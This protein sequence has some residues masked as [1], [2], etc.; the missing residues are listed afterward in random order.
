MIRLIVKGHEG[1]LPLRLMKSNRRPAAWRH[2][3]E[4]WVQHRHTDNAAALTFYALISLAP[5]LLFGVTLAGVILGETTAHGE[6][7]RQ[8][9][10]VIGS[11][12]AAGI[13]SMLRSARIA[14]RSEPWAFA[15][16]M[17][18][19]L[20]A[21]SHVLSKLRLSLNQV[22]EAVPA[23][24]GRK[25][26][27]R[28]LARSLCASL[29]LVFGVLLVAATALEGAAGYVAARVD[30]PL[31]EGLHFMQ[32]WRWISSYLLLIVALALILKILPRRR[33][34]WRHA[35]VGAAVA[36]LVVGSLKTVLDFY[37]R[38]TMWASVIGSGI[39]LL[40]FL[41]W[42]F[43]SIQAFLAGAELAAWLGKRSLLRNK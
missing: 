31:L 41:L 39:T 33:P 12:A 43:F 38:R 8:L 17:I 32:G 23:D 25:W 14:P 37:L 30:L 1:R 7:L 9:S 4:R 2:F 11:D 19:L 21:G 24:P 18:T 15:L 34:K 20:Y 6:L 3:S 16:A 29:I 36:A 22:N 13:E 40:I 28:I 35:L 26:L 27:S 5:L 42:L 10:S